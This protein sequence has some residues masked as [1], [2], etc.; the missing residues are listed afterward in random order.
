MTKW[1][2]AKLLQAPREDAEQVYDRIQAEP[3]AAHV[4][5]KRHREVLEPNIIVCTLWNV[6]GSRQ[7]PV[8]KVFFKNEF[9]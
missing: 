2:N 6:N 7:A 8:L 1:I 3:S 9:M 5:P 4:G